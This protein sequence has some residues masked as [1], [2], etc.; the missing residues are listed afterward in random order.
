MEGTAPS[1]PGAIDPPPEKR[2]RDRPFRPICGVNSR[3][4]AFPST[5][6]FTRSFLLKCQLCLTSF[7]CLTGWEFNGCQTPR[8]RSTVRLRVFTEL[9]APLTS[10][11]RIGPSQQMPLSSAQMLSGP[12]LQQPTKRGVIGRRCCHNRMF[13]GRIETRTAND[14]EDESGTSARCIRVKLRAVSP[15]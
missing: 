2:A 9:N 3:R 13:E 14:H 4:S 11:P 6:P 10:Q 7:T 12:I 15:K 8:P 5:T 1:V